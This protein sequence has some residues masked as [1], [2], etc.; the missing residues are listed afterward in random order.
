M[1][2][3]PRSGRPEPA[4]HRRDSLARI[5]CR[6]KGLVSPSSPLPAPAA[7]Q[8]SIRLLRIIAGSTEAGC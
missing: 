1:A 4:R 3:A 8:Q 6:V 7:L 5:S 2:V